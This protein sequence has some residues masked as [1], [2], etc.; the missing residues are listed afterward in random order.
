M[1][2]EIDIISVCKIF[3]KGV[4]KDMQLVKMRVEESAMKQNVTPSKNAQSDASKKMINEL[5]DDIQNFIAH[6]FRSW[7]FDLY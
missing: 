4:E 2:C 7:N 3:L 5:L 1:Y 6:S